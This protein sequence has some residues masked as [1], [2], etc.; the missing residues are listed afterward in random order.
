[1]KRK[2]KMKREINKKREGYIEPILS[3][4]TKHP[5]DLFPNLNYNKSNVIGKNTSPFRLKDEKAEK[6]T[7]EKGL[8]VKKRVQSAFSRLH[9]ESKNKD[10]FKDID[11]EAIEKNIPLA[12]SVVKKNMAS[13]PLG[14]DT[15]KNH[16]YMTDGLALFYAAAESGNHKAANEARKLAYTEVK[17][18]EKSKEEDLRKSSEEEKAKKENPKYRGLD[19]LSDILSVAS[20]IPGV[21]TFADLASIPVDLLR[22]D[23]VSAGLSALGAIPFVGEVADTAKL[24]N[25]ADKIADV[26]KGA[27]KAID[28]AKAVDKAAD[29]AKGVDRIADASKGVKKT[30]KSS[31]AGFPKKTHSGKQGKHIVGHNNYIKGK[32]IFN[33]T[34]EDAG[35]LI[36]KFGG[37]GTKKGTNKEI[38]DFGQVIGKYVDPNTGKLY[39]TTMGTIHYSKSGAH[40]VP[41]RPKIKK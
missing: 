15:F 37:T 2:E 23:F 28:A 6:E 19:A 25:T 21:D 26:A 20:L 34:T 17:E 10:L 3:E 9:P 41:S 4:N 16:P 11:E 40:I 14:R 8:E 24:A 39:N 5:I 33:G 1:L 30:S 18:P 31:F 13:H 36:K 35:K 32:S 7:S 38:V 22:G 27:D 12:E 29:A